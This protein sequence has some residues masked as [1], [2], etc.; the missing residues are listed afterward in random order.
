MVQR[1]RKNACMGSLYYQSK[2]GTS[3]IAAPLFG[4]RS[5]ELIGGYLKSEQYKDLN[6]SQD[7]TQEKLVAKLFIPLSLHG[8]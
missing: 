5:N 4:L 8:L 6:P 1:I 7:F 3:S 2:E